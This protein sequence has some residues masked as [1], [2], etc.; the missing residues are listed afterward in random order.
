MKVLIVDDDADYRK[1]VGVVFADNGWETFE[2]ADGKEGLASAMEV[3]PDLILSDAMMPVM[4]GYQ[5]LR[6]LRR[7]PIKET[8]FIFCTAT[9]LKDR[10]RVLAE[11]LGADAFIKKPLD[12]DEMYRETLAIVSRG[13][14]ERAP[15][16]TLESE[17]VFLKQYSEVVTMKLQEKVQELEDR[18][19][20]FLR[21]EEELSTL[22]R[23]TEGRVIQAGALPRPPEERRNYHFTISPDA[24][25]PV[26]KIR[27]ICN[28][29]MERLEKM[30][31][32]GRQYLQ[33][34]CRMPDK[35][36]KLMEDMLRLPHSRSEVFAPV[37][38]IETMVEILSK[39]HGAELGEQGKESIV[40]IKEALRQVSAVLDQLLKL[41][42]LST[43]PLKMERVD[44]SYLAADVVRDLRQRGP[45]RKAEIEIGEGLVA[46]GDGA[47]LR[48]MLEH[49][50][51]DSWK[52]TAKADMAKISFGIVRHGQPHFFIRD[53]GIGFKSADADK[54]FVAFQKVPPRETGHVG[55][56]AAKIIVERH[57]G[58]IWAESGDGAG[59]T[60]NFLLHTR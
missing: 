11:S 59:A 43:A 56:T 46:T 24:H 20:A 15:G 6:E 39:E 44:L 38:R 10:D 22:K 29:L 57:N 25:L 40:E 60:F 42:Q 36:R 52:A 21:A 55:L 7:S 16:E 23:Q 47:M 53:N 18:S 32:Q 41:I 51:E 31:E 45:E 3:R 2:A 27:Y 8:F 28:L 48:T 19:Q 49:L 1:L 13:R 54:L 58:R 35:V 5:F 30:N 9:Y 37:K 34:I 33:Q 17:E 12:P 14:H 26:V 4:D 50:F